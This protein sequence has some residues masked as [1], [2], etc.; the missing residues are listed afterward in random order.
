MRPVIVWF[1]RDLRLCDHPALTHA[2]QTGRPVLHVFICDR[3]VDALGAAPAWRLEQGLA[4][5]SRSLETL[6]SRLVLR[7]GDAAEVLDDLIAETG[8]DAVF[9]TR[10]YDGF[11]KA[12]DSALKTSLKARGIDARSFPGHLLTEPLTIRTQAGQPF[13]VYSAFWRAVRKRID[14]VML[15]APVRIAAPPDWPVSERLGDW[16]LGAGMHRGAAVVSRHVR[17]GEAAAQDRLDR[18]MAGAVD[19]YGTGRDDL[20]DPATSGLSAFLSLGE[21]SVHRCWAAAM[22]WFEAGSPGAEAYLKELVWREFA[23]HLLHH[24]PG[25]GDRNWRRDWDGFPWL[26]D[27]DRPELRAWQQGRTGIALVDAAMR[28]MYVTGTMHN[29]ARMVVASFLTKHLMTDWRIGLRW[30][31][32]HLVDWDPASNAMGWQWVAGSGPDAAPF[33]RIFNPDTQAAKFDPDGRYLRRWI[34]EGQGTPPETALDYF[35]AIPASWARSPDDPRPDPVIS[36]AA[37][38]ERALAAYRN[39]K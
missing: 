20:S 36:L 33:F 18:F 34:A 4:G 6:G 17:V 13:R 2:V 23:Y 24:F 29:R 7:S 10:L 26:A 28:E 35:R 19:S 39:M 9:W 27:E 38:R 3:S 15:A 32:Q 22:R 1:R 37:G 16:N 31:E 8:A 5:F 12:R 14:P 21:L 25:L 11:S 30:F